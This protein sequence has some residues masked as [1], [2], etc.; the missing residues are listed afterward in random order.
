[1]RKDRDYTG[2]NLVFH[3]W[4]KGGGDLNLISFEQDRI[5]LTGGCLY[6]EN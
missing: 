4:V 2:I 6:D 3:C 5:A 1:M